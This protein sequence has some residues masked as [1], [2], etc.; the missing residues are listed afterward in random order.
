MG[1][2]EVFSLLIVVSIPTLLIFYLAKR[3]F[4]LKEKK[5]GIEALN[6]A[7]NAAQY[8]ARSS[9]IEDRLAV[10]ERIVTDRPH[11]LAR[12]IDS[13]AIAHQKERA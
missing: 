12:E 13:L 6:A 9:E 3:Y 4:T 11:A 2:G 1:P 8:V 10:I 7:E 5:L